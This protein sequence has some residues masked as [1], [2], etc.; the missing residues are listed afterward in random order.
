MI[1]ESRVMVDASVLKLLFD[2]LCADGIL[3]ACKL[4]IIE[5]S[6]GPAMPVIPMVSVP[7]ASGATYVFRHNS[8]RYRAQEKAPP[9]EASGSGGSTHLAGHPGH[10]KKRRD[11][12][13]VCLL[14]HEISGAPIVDHTGRCVGILSAV[15]FM[16]KSCKCGRTISFAPSHRMH[17]PL[18]AQRTVSEYRVQLSRAK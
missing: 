13:S 18:K 16:K 8:E 7:Q 5:A 14:R 15:D 1:H 9:A 11:T 4:A 10:A 6:K 12:R 3:A 17:R 2:T